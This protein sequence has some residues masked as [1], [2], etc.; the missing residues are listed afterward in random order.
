MTALD[1]M[2]QARER[3]GDEKKQRWSDNRL[4]SIVSQGQV[5][6]CIQSGYLRKEILLP[7]VVGKTRFTLPRDCYS[8]RRVEFQDKLL[9]LHTRS[10]QD[11]PR[12]ATKSEF[13]AYKSNLQTNRIE[14]QPAI[15][16][17]ELNILYADGDAI[18]D[19]LFVANPYGVVVYT[20]DPNMTVSPLYGCTTGFGLSEDVTSSTGYGAIAGSSLD[21]AAVDF[22]NGEFG[23]VVAA[24]YITVDTKYGSITAVDG[25]IVSGVYGIVTDVAAVSDTFHVYY[26]ATPDK[27][28]FAQSVLILPERWEELLIRYTVGTAL[29]DDNDANNITR[30]EGELQKYAVQLE[31]I[32]ALS[33]QDFAGSSSEKMQTTYRR[34]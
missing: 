21:V 31:Q 15:S 12:H 4:L 20:N 9:P 8:V 6:V 18:E 17:L 13:I 27:L 30:G 19:S 2:N 10:D 5:N 22:P 33:S 24:D 25:H 3:L 11:V 28:K 1:I 23:V 16:E 32:K 14:I 29:Q 26:I 34:I 7:F